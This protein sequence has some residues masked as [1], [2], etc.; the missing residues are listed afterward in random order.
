LVRGES[1]GRD[2]TVQGHMTVVECL[3]G[4]HRVMG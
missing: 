1:Q 2:Y 3:P 4:E